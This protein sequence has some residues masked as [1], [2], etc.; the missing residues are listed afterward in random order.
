MIYLI[1]YHSQAFEWQVKIEGQMQKR[2]LGCWWTTYWVVLDQTAIRFYS[3]EQVLSVDSEL[4]Q[5][6]SI[7]YTVQ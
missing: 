4:K 3:S 7:Y 5:R 2:S 1:S 6:A